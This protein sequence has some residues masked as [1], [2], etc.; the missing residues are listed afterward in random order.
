M[1][2][3]R[4][5]MILSLLP[6]QTWAIDP[7]V[8]LKVW[9][10]EAIINVYSFSY[11]TWVK[12]QQDM[13]AYFRPEAWKAYLDAINKSNVLKLVMQNQ[14]T[15]SAVATLPPSIKMVNAQ[16]Y[17]AHMPILV[18]YASANNTQVQYLSIDL[19]IIK[20]SAKSTRGYAINRFE[21]SIDTKPCLCS[22][23]HNQKKVTIV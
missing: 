5:A 15:V 9:T 7:D 19:D 21:A 1:K 12:R 22:D 3:K 4:Y 10:N 2:I 23:E 20:S 13:G 18:Q 17:H 16:T 11:Q 6:L 14:M 8:T